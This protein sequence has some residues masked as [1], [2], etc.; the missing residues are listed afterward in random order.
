[1]AAG[2]NGVKLEKRVLKKK[3]RKANKKSTRKC[4]VCLYSLD[5]TFIME[6]TKLLG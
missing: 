6:M 5:E 3:L 4:H 1:M 2:C